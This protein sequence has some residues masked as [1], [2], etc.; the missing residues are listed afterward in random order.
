MTGQH[1]MTTDTIMH[2]VAGLQFCTHVSTAP[3]KN[4]ALNLAVLKTQ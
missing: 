1:C 2:N 4:M 3:I